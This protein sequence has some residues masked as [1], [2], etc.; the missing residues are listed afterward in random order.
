LNSQLIIHHPYRSLTDLTQQLAL[1][2]D[3]TLLAWNI[4]NDHYFTDLP[5]IHPPY[6]IAVTA[7]LLAVALKPVTQGSHIQPGPMQ[8]AMQQIGASGATPT[9]PRLQRIMNWIAESSISLEAMADCAQEL[10]SLYEAWEGYK[11]NLIKDPIARFVKAR[12][13]EK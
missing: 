4:I 5:F 2:V 7:L 8:T 1:T 12:G 3:E 11:E 9:S 6:I 10:M 13:L